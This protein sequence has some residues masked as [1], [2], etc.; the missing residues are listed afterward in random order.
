[1]TQDS[2]QIISAGEGELYIASTTALFPGDTTDPADHLDTTGLLDLPDDTDWIEMGW[3]SEDGA[4]FSLSRDV[5]PIKGWG[6]DV[7]R[8][9]VREI[10]L[11]VQF[12]LLQMN[13]DNVPFAFG[14][15]DFT[16]A[17]TGIFLFEPPPLSELDERALII[18]F[19]DRGYDYRLGFP[20]GT[21][22]GDST[23][24]MRTGEAAPLPVTFSPVRKSHNAKAFFFV[25][26][27]PAFAPAA[28]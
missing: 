16:E 8:Q 15:G 12:T 26:N 24:A 4:S 11:G 10:I 6:G 13:V 3:A 9:I 2:A 25:S 23:L 18:D 19:H 22:T 14:G 1:M 21:V 17:S 27:D 5:N 7:L 20:Q 28:S